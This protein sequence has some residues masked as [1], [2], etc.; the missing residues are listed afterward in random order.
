[1]ASA[2]ISIAPEALTKL[3]WRFGSISP[4]SSVVLEDLDRENDD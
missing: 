2:D 3:L 4:S 1:M